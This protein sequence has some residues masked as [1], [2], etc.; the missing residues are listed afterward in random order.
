M[1]LYF[2][3]NKT[4]ARFTG[5]NEQ[6]PQPA[7]RRER[8]RATGQ[9]AQLRDMCPLTCL[10][11]LFPSCPQKLRA[12]G[13][14]SENLKYF[15]SWNRREVSSRYLLPPFGG[16]F[17]LT[18]PMGALHARNRQQW[19]DSQRTPKVKFAV[20]FLPLAVEREVSYARKISDQPFQVRLEQK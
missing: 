15:C 2:L 12:Q 6:R 4:P 7:V 14:S 19:N 11:V 8:A 17:L 1:W 5:W 20:T 10:G 18:A 16:N 9:G 3:L 13:E